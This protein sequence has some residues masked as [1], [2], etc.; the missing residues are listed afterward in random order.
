MSTRCLSFL[1]RPTVQPHA[2]PY[3]RVLVMFAHTGTPGLA[4]NK[5]YGERPPSG[6]SQ[7]APRPGKGY[8]AA[9]AR[10]YFHHRV[11]SAHAGVHERKDIPTT[12]VVWEGRHNY[13][14]HPPNDAPT[15]LAQRGYQRYPYGWVCNSDVCGGLGCFDDLALVVRLDEVL[16]Y[17]KGSRTRPPILINKGCG[18][19]RASHTR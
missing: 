4:D 13:Y 11:A 14:V 8:P 16:A 2:S 3:K 15:K 12:K 1:R 9:I 6:P 17:C 7:P 18:S 5:E 19:L 10:P